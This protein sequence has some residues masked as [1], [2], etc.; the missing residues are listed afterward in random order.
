MTTEITKTDHAEIA[1]L[2]VSAL[3]LEIAP[4]TV[5]PDDPLFG[6]GLGLDSIDALELAMEISRR[7]GIEIEADNPE[8]PKIFASLRAL[9]EF[10]EKHRRK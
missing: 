10:I 6:D 4:E 7:Y 3:N 2:I 1:A 8:T 5:A 9:T